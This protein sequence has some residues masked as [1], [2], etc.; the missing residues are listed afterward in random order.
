MTIRADALPRE[1]AFESAASRGGTILV[2]RLGCAFP[3]GPEARDRWG[4]LDMGAGGHEPGLLGLHLR[5]YGGRLAGLP[6]LSGAHLTRLQVGV[7]GG[8]RG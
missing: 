4:C 6:D 7:W 3:P 1:V 5:G 2:P 8:A